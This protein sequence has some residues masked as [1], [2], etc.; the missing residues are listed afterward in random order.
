MS[1]VF[2]VDLIMCHDRE[3]QS[4]DMYSQRVANPA[5]GFAC[6]SPCLFP[7]FSKASLLLSPTK[8]VNIEGAAP[9]GYTETRA[10]TKSLDKFIHYNQAVGHDAWQGLQKDYNVFTPLG[11][12]HMVDQISVTGD[13]CAALPQG[14]R[15]NCDRFDKEPKSVW[16]PDTNC[17]L[18]TMWMLN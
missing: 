14:H 8:A 4:H 5:A 18:A 7:L 17:C 10:V 16:Q 6:W 13:Q 12:H 3:K 11:F 2:H 1:D 9:H 15:H